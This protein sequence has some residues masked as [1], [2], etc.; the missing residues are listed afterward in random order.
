MPTPEGAGV[1][2]ANV[3][4]G[5]AAFWLEAFLG[6]RGAAQPSRGDELTWQCLR[7]PGPPRRA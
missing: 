5:E 7:S 1:W 4:K 2:G 6:Q 3:S